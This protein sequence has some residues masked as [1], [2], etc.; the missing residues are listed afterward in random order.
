[1]DG[2]RKRFGSV[3]VDIAL[4][5]VAVGV[6]AIAVVIWV[7]DV[8]FG[9]ILAFAIALSPLWLPIVLFFIFFERWMYFVRKQFKL[10]QGNVTLEILI[11][12]EIYKSPL[13][14]ELVLTHLFQKA[15]PDN[16]VQTY[17]DGKHPPTFS[18][19]LVSDGGTVRFFINTPRKKFKNIIET[20]LYSQ[21]PGIEIRELPVD[22]TAEIEGSLND[23]E[24]FSIHFG[25]KKDD[26]YPIKTYID[27]GLDMNPKE[28]EK[29][30]PITQMLDMLGSI[31]PNERIWI[32]I[33]ISAHRTE[34]FEVGS[35]S[36]K[37]DWS[38]RIKKEI[39]KIAG[40]DDKG[41]A[42]IEIEAMPRMTDGERD[43]VK[44]LERSLS[45]TPFNTAIR[46]VYAAKPGSFVPGERIGA[47]ITAW[48]QYNDNRS[49][50]FA[51]K[52][53]TDYNWP[54]WQDPSG[55]KRFAHKKRELSEY[56]RRHFESQ[57]Q[58]DD[59]FIMTNEELATL[60]HLPGKVALTPSLP[61]IPS[62][63]GEAPP[64]L[65]TTQR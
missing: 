10:D 32:Q 4:P 49:N 50:T 5:L 31:G 40:R 45:K 59:K 39:N 24:L 63:R 37:P 56:K 2:I 20:Q 58:G 53:R 28:E 12:E 60:F 18:L 9:R 29:V 6:I 23:F 19:E 64:N 41:L 33:L 65:P 14:M 15:G 1:M 36:T 61:R 34:D 30:D 52:W 51:L 11:P 26:I 46:A 57:T 43:T 48:F 55:R 38:D 3:G 25:L 13:A 35:L 44:A 47:I 16:L 21:Y 8:S 62:A 17:W 22:Y 7:I 27:Y 42:P 54:W